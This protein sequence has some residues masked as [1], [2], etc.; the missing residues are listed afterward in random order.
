MR[1]GRKSHSSI[2]PP[3]SIYFCI[4]VN[5][6][7]APPSTVTRS[8]ARISD[9][10]IKKHNLIHKTVERMLAT[11]RLSLSSRQNT[12]IVVGFHQTVIV[13]IQSYLTISG[14]IIK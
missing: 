8:A 14:E 2:L 1:S 13:E 4:V 9:Y 10:K 5:Q 11:I 6:L 12:H 3:P 7:L